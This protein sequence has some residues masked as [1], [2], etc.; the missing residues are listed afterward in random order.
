MPSNKPTKKPNGRPRV[1]DREDLAKKL[2]EYIDANDVPIVAE[3]AYLNGVSKGR[4]YEMPELAELIKKA[5]T[6]KEAAL[7]R[8]T[9]N[10]SLCV[11]MAIFSLK[12]L[13]WRD[14]KQE[15]CADIKITGGLPD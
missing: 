13:G 2:Q 14:N 6:K 15:V 11:P 1:H 4:L 9:L 12:Q 10:G 3:F 7:E 5:T 8:G